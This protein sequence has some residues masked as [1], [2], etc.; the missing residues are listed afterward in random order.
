[1]DALIVAAAKLGLYG[2]I[3]RSVFGLLK[4]LL[5]RRAVEWK[6]W[7]LMLFTTSAIGTFLG[8]LLNFNPTISLLSGYAGFDFLDT[9]TKTFKL[10][11]VKIPTKSIMSVKKKTV[12]EKAMEFR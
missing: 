7:F 3:A 1:M 9:L 8:G 4:A 12:W 11:A 10:G 5:D 2:G 6:S